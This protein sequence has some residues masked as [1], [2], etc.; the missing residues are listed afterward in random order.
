MAHPF[1]RSVPALKLILAATVGRWRAW[2]A[3]DRR[4]RNHTPRSST[5]A[6]RVEAVTERPPTRYRG[7]HRRGRLTPVL[8]FRSESEAR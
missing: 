7:K 3:V 4:R 8:S 1:D 5:T 6:G 2:R